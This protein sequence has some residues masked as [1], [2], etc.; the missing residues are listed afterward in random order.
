MGKCV[1]LKPAEEPLA[2]IMLSSIPVEPF[3]LGVF[4]SIG[5][6][7]KLENYDVIV[8]KSRMYCRPVFAPLV[9]TVI[10]CDSRGI[11]SSDYSLFDFKHLRRPIFPLVP[12]L[13]FL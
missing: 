1:V 5:G 8:L 6:V 2:R 11:T 10:E 7:D 4:E 12:N 9:D 3:D 13:F